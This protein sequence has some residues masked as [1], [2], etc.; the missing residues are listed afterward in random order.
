MGRTGRSLDKTLSFSLLGPPDIRLGERTL[1]PLPSRKVLALLIYLAVESS[2]SHDRKALA[3][4]FW[5]DAPRKRGSPPSGNPF[6]PFDGLLATS[7]SPGPF[8]SPIPARWPSTP[9]PPTGWT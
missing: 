9:G 3:L 4:L 8:S 6:S 7:G 5:P 2:R 1:A